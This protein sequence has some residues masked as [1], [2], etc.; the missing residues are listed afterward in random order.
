MSRRITLQVSCRWHAQH[1]GNQAEATLLGGQLDLRVRP[2]FGAVTNDPR[3]GDHQVAKDTSA[4]RQ[5]Q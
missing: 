2:H 4:T 1:D 3:D 5:L